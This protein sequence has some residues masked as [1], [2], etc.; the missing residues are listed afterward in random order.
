MQ[1]YSAV[2]KLS[3]GNRKTFRKR[4]NKR[5]ETMEANVKKALG[6]AKYIATT[7]DGWSKYH[8]GFL[9]MTAHWIEEDTMERESA[10]LALRRLRGR[11]TYDRLAMEMSSVLKHY[12][13]VPD[14]FVKTTTDSASNF[15]KSFRVFSVK[16]QNTGKCTV[17]KS[18]VECGCRVIAE[19][20]LFSVT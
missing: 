15:R 9:G 10:A 19:R 5:R 12:S 6:R 7:A 3:V 20:D 2:R 17:R 8:R 4:L 14:K 16:E 18:H 11:H 13:I 1:F